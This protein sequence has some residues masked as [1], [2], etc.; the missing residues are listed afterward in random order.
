M[1]C[2][3]LF[4][5]YDVMNA[6]GLFNLVFIFGCMFNLVYSLCDFVCTSM[7]HLFPIFSVLTSVC[8]L[9]RSMASTNKSEKRIFLAP[10]TL[11]K[12]RAQ[13]LRERGLH[14]SPSTKQHFPD[15][16]SSLKEL[17]H[18]EASPEVLGEGGETTN[19]AVLN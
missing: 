16:T 10:R 6:V 18:V 12:N 11:C 2:S 8:F 1:V 9:Q 14:H 19:V 4:G 17:Q 15:V 13:S 7:F 3:V 5:D